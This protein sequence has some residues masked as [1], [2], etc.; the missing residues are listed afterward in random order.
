M[1]AALLIGGGAAALIEI[2]RTDRPRTV[3]RA[4]MDRVDEH[5]IGRFPAGI[6]RDH[7]RGQR[8]GQPSAQDQSEPSTLE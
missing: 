5:G 7:V 2:A 6:L 8:G 4:A 1:I 3:R